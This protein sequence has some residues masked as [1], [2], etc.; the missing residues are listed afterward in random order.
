MARYEVRVSKSVSKDLAPVPK[1]D[2]RR[3]VRAI[4]G[5]A[6]NPRPPESRRLGGA[7]KCRLRCGN[8]RVLY[9]IEDNVLLVVVVRVG[10]R[11]DVYRD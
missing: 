5:L 10:H 4:A 2:A 9:Q 6:E 11:R 8:Y 1:Q 3:I 7:E